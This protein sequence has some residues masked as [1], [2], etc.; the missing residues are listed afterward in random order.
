VIA[1]ASLCTAII[2][3]AVAGRWLWTTSI[4]P[5]PVP[6]VTSFDLYSLAADLTP[7]TVSVAGAENAP[8]QTTIDELRRNRGL[9]QLMSLENWSAVPSPLREEMLDRILADY[10]P[11][12]MSPRVWDHMT[13]SEWDDVPQPVRTVAYRQMAAFWAGYYA[14]GER[15]GLDRRRVRD[16]LEAIVMSE[17]WFEHR[18]EN[19]SVPGN[20]DIGL[21]QASTYARERVRQLASAGIVDV[22]FA[23][24]DYWDPWRATRFLA[25][26][27]SL[28]LDEAGGDL[29]RA[30]RAYNRGIARADDA[31]G[32]AY[33]DTVNRRRWRFIQNHNAPEAWSWVWRRARQIEAQEWPWILPWGVGRP[34]ARTDGAS[35]PRL[36]RD[37]SA[38]AGRREAPAVRA[39]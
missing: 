7:I 11:L 35:S 6:A 10:R 14:V 21:V 8:W 34:P 36:T 24:A 31:I 19:A 17:S 37:P 20:H 32:M 29:D 26:W 4:E 30:V 39:R 25:V 3:A 1:I 18:A 16:T 33:L 12:L 22:S 5:A 13:V 2:L 28:L 15:Y 23:D 9:W 38:R 27:M